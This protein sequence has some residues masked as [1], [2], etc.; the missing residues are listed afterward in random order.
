M[1][2]V[3]GGMRMTLFGG[4]VARERAAACSVYSLFYGRPGKGSRVAARL[5]TACR[6]LALTTWAGT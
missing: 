1:A 4:A 6:W 2:V 5:E 3:E